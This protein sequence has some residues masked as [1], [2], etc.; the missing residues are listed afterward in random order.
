MDRS[1]LAKIKHLESSTM[2]ILLLLFLFATVQLLFRGYQFG[3]NDHSIEIPFIKKNMDSSLYPGDPMVGT[4]DEFVTIY[5]WIPTVLTLIAGNM[6]LVFFFLQMLAFFLVAVM[7][8]HIC[9]RLFRD[10]TSAILGLVLIF[11]QKFVLGG[12]AIHITSFV[13]SFSIL[14]VASKEL[15]LGMVHKNGGYRVYQF[16]AE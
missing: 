14:P 4:R 1:V 5:T 12:S 6:E 9:L 10:R 8:Y 11:P 3:V 7:V 13:P 16:H 2:L 15:E